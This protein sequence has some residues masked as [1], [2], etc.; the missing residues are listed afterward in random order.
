MLAA[1][2]AEAGRSLDEALTFA[3]KAISFEPGNSDYQLALAQ[4]LL[5]RNKLDEAEIA[6]KRAIALA[7]EPSE[8]ANAENFKNFLDKFR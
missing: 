3:H 4:V 2:L 8:K 7:R 5:R 1:Y 6:A